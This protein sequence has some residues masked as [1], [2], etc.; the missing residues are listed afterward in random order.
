MQFEPMAIPDVVLIMPN[1]HSDARG[2][3][4]E[5]FRA[6]LFAE[7]I[8]PFSFV[9]DNQSLSALVG[10]VRGLHFQLNPRAQGKLVR[11]VTGAIVDVAVDIRLGS[12]T[13]GQYIKAELSADN[14]HQLWI[15]PSFAHGFC[16]ILPDCT[17]AYKV[18]DYYYSA[19]H[20]CGLA[21]NDP[22]LAIAWPIA[23][24]QAVLSAKDK[25]LPL[26]AELSAKLVSA[27]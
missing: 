11:C 23:P 8:G 5:T 12:P 4:M 24:D 20:D 10:T 22:A 18:T 7:R 17:I 9:Q 2:Y 6:D 15:P 21:W 19:P 16:T 27:G 25:A 26:L 3:F 1:R 14:G 13:F